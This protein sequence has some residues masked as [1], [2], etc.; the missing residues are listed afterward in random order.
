M[1]KKVS[2]S[3]APKVAASVDGRIMHND[4]GMEV[5]LLTIRP[6]E[7]IPMHKNLFDVLFAGITGKATLVSPS[8]SLTLQ[9]GETIFISAA[10]DRAWKNPGKE[11]ARIFVIKIL[12]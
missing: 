5:I 7:E 6:G 12:E 11:T 9:E 3:T 10:E 8:E 1:I 2:P 4:P